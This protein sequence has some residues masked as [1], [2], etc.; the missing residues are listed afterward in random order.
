MPFTKSTGRTPKLDKL[1]AIQLIIMLLSQNKTVAK[2]LSLSVRTIYNWKSKLGQTEPNKNPHSE[3]KDL[4]KHYYEIKDQNP[5]ISDENIAKMLKI[6]RRTLARWKKQFKR[7]ELHPN[8]V[9]GHSV[10]ENAA[11]NVQE[12]A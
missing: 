4:M 3:Q 5:K 6:G 1:N 8:S 2:E 10:E 9:D 11:A 7:Q 12:I